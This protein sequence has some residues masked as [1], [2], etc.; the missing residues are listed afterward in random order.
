MHGSGSRFVE[1]GV[2]ARH[3]VEIGSI[4]LHIDSLVIPDTWRT[5]RDGIVRSLQQE[6][7]ALL[8]DGKGLFSPLED[9]ELDRLSPGTVR[10]SSDQSGRQIGREMAQ[11]ICQGLRHGHKNA[12][13]N[14]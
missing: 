12:R 13:R 11:I 4:E 9:R 7:T 1:H 2:T 14:D 8:S 3:E 6:L 10:L 5:Q